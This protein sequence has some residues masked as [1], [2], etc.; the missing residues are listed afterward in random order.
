MKVLALTLS[1]AISACHENHDQ[2]KDLGKA[3]DLSQDSDLAKASDLGT[4][5]DL[6]PTSNLTPVPPSAGNFG[7]QGLQTQFKDSS[8][9]TCSGAVTIA[10]GDQAMCFVAADDSLR[11]AGVVYMKNFGPRFTATGQTGVDQILLGTTTN[12]TTGNQ[13]CIHKLDGTV[14]CTGFGNVVKSADFTPW[15]TLKN[16][17]AIG[18]GTFDQLCGIDTTGKIYCSG[19]GISDTPVVQDGGK[20]HSFFWQD[21]YGTPR[22]DDPSVLRVSAGRSECQ[23]QASGLHCPFATLGTP[24]SVVDGSVVESMNGDQNREACFLTAD[25]KVTCA[26]RDIHGM[27]TMQPV[28]T[29]GTV[30]SLA[31]NY[32]TTSMCA[33]YSDGSLYC[34]GSNDLG[35]LGTGDTMA[36]ATE[37]MV[38]PPGS[39]RINCHLVR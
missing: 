11:C 25:G 8:G 6:R 2:D 36:L 31:A 17:V 10:M 9:L 29:R 32:Y 18:T 34:V 37:T 19:A 38:Q 26:R 33:V 24:G 21:T 4:V 16:L 14:L 1:L 13:L 30:L 12:I 27:Y 35:K 22:A 23:V 39:V 28:F 7:W 3:T 5:S 20:S 15:G